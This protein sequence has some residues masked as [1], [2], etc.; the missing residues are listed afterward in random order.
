MEE[1][2]RQEEIV[3]FVFSTAPGYRVVAANAIWGGLTPRGELKMDFM[4]DSVLTPD[5][6]TH[7]VTPEGGLGPELEREPSQRLLSR[8]LQVGILLSVGHAENIAQW[9]LE[10][11]KEAKKR[12][13]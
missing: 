9:I 11:V 2:G 1:H 6:V 5:S 12:G 8:E 13:A 7:S 4:I 3:K 10:K